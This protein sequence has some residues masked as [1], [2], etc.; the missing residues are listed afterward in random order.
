MSVHQKKTTENF[1]SAELQGHLI[2]NG[3]AL[4]VFAKPKWSRANNWFINLSLHINET[5]L[6]L[7]PLMELVLKVSSEKVLTMCPVEIKQ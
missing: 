4:I 3:T 7:I 5:V 2:T 6:I 1:F